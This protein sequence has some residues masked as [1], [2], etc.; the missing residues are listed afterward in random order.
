MIFYNNLLILRRCDMQSDRACAVRIFPEYPFSC[1]E[2]HTYL[3][4]L[5]IKYVIHVSVKSLT[6][7]INIRAQLF[8]TND[9]VVNVSSKL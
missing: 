7:Q 9:V 3:V 1:D 2:T 5:C 4:V 8:K 6:E